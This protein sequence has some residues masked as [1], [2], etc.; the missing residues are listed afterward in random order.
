MPLA[1]S[2]EAVM[3]RSERVAMEKKEQQ[4]RERLSLPHSLRNKASSSTASTA[5]VTSDAC[6]EARVK[7]R[8]S[9]R[10]RESI[11][12]FKIRN[13]KERE[14]LEQERVKENTTVNGS[15][16]ARASHRSKIYSPPVTRSAKKLRR[17]GDDSIADSTS[18]SRRSLVMSFSPPDQ[19]ENARR[20]QE[21]LEREEA[22]Q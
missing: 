3:R 7:R 1:S 13:K 9:A 11:A 6:S 19:E 12:E 5:S 2:R 16:P 22:E 15:S 20:E 14:R 21:R 18:S 10:H 4:R 8:Q 17:Q